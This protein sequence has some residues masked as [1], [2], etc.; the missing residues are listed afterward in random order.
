MKILIVKTSAIGDVTHTLPALNAIRRM[1]PA[2]LITWLIE[3]A[4]ADI[5]MG[6]ENVDRVLVAKRKSWIRDLKKI[7]WK[8]AIREIWAFIRALRDTQYDILIDF[9]GLLKSSIWIFLA[10]AKRK[11][12]FG[13]GMQHQEG[14]YIFLNEHIPAIN[15]DTHAV[16]RELYLLSK[17]GLNIP[18]EIRFAIPITDNDRIEIET[19]LY[20]KKVPKTKKLISIHPIVGWPTRLWIAS[21]FSE[22]ADRLIDT[23]NA[24]II[25]TGS[26]V[27]QKAIREIQEKMKYSSVMLAGE[28]TLLTLAALYEKSRLIVTTDTG[29]M[30]IAAAINQPVVAIFG[31]TAPWRT[32]PYTKKARVIRA[33]LDCMPCFK[34]NCKTHA[35]MES[36]HVDDVLMGINALWN[37]TENLNAF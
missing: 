7:R 1:Y 37:E 16:D 19:L 20:K 21:R 15:M 6:H 30:H 2:A 10:H 9:Q 8:I 4:A 25:F 11:I 5:V 23:Y 12:G 35:C 34:R 18:K 17:I 33:N 26:V 28:T 24:T 31:P 27:D 36:I 32:G 3:E 29:P 14:S 13:K 22:L